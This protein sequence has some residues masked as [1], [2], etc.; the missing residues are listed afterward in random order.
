[1]I[2]PFARV[3][4]AHRLVLARSAG[5]VAVL[6]LGAMAVLGG[7]L[8]GD[9]APL[10]IV[11]LQFAG[12]PEAAASILDSWASVPRLRLLWA[13]GLDL[14]F[15]LAYALAI[16]L[17]AAHVAHASQRAVPA[18]AVA[19]GSAIAAAVAD[20]VENVAMWVT[21]LR[22]PDWTSVL[23][24]LVA[25]TVKFSAVGLALG[26]LAVASAR[27]RSDARRSLA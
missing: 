2:G 10:G 20:Q 6:L 23:P 12:T 13:H 22:G 5:V 4:A 7:P 8:Q 19:T 24:T 9:L 26:A 11:S 21:I 1:M 27:A 18:A 14:A 16:G 3:P 17:T 25:A 15:P